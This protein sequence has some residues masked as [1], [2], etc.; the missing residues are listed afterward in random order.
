MKHLAEDDTDTSQFVLLLLPAAQVINKEERFHWWSYLLTSSQH[1]RRAS[2]MRCFGLGLQCSVPV[3]KRMI[4]E[5]G[6]RFLIWPGFVKAFFSSRCFG[7]ADLTP[8][9]FPFKNAPYIFDLLFFLSY[10]DDA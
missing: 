5:G 8:A 10:D 4:D 9:F 1:H 3:E 7:I 2:R 6:R